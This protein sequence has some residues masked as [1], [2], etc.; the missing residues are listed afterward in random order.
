MRMLPKTGPKGEIVANPG[1]SIGNLRG[2]FPAIISARLRGNFRGSG[3]TY[4][5]L[6]QTCIVSSSG[7]FANR[8]VASKE[9]IV[10]LSCLACTF[11]PVSK[12]K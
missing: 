12:T 8:E 10:S 6:R 3:R 2:K 5:L 11:W 4:S 1:R 9:H 7:T